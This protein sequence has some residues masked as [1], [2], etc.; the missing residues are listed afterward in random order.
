[1]SAASQADLEEKNFERAFSV[2]EKSSDRSRSVIYIV[3]VINFAIFVGLFNGAT[4]DFA[5]ER[6]KRVYS[7]F[8]CLTVEQ[9][10]THARRNFCVRLLDAYAEQ[11]L[12]FRAYSRSGAHPNSQVTPSPNTTPTANRLDEA[13]IRMIESRIFEVAR[14]SIADT[15]FRIP[16][17]GVEF[18]AELMWFI[19]TIVGILS[20]FIVQASVSRENRNF[21]I[22]YRYTH[23]QIER[24][25]LLSTTQ[26]L[27]VVFRTEDDLMRS[28]IGTLRNIFFAIISLAPIGSLII[29]ISSLIEFN[30]LVFGN[31]RGYFWFALITT[32]VGA[33]FLITVTVALWR[34]FFIQHRN[35]SL[36][37]SKIAEGKT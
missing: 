20:I 36:L 3:I 15:R 1:M 17:L 2:L 10:A 4:I 5:F 28:I 31:F 13:K 25:E 6:V 32:I 8:D 21:Q 9:N 19:A 23:D 33:V 24:L 35:Y 37:A 29:V 11:G 18:Q 7:A 30:Y 12:D 16:I 22:V 14:Q 27:A 26:V 34:E